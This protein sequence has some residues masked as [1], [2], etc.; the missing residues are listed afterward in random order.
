LPSTG[1][2]NYEG[3]VRVE[4]AWFPSVI[5]D[6]SGPSLYS[7]NIDQMYTYESDLEDEHGLSASD[8]TGVIPGHQGRHVS[9]DNSLR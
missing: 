2:Q 4:D 9:L 3:A 5:T 1:R 8:L 7:W 6:P